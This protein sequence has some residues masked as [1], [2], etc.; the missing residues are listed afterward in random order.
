M[1]FPGSSERPILGV[2]APAPSRP[3]IALGEAFREAAPL[4][5]V[6]VPTS[7]GP[8]PFSLRAPARN[9]LWRFFAQVLIRLLIIAP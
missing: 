9:P 1:R 6:E 3:G 8:R 7:Y 4:L 2:M 5:V